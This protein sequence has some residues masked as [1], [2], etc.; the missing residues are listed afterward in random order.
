MTETETGTWIVDNGIVA[1]GGTPERVLHNGAVLWQGERIVEV[2]RAAELGARH[3]EAQHLDAR[4]G[5]I[6]P[7]L[8]NLHH[9]LYS[10]PARGLD[11]GI[12][13][14]GFGPVLE[15]LWWRLD[16]ALDAEAVRLAAALTLTEC[17][18]TGCTTLFDHHASPA[19]LDGSLDLIAAEVERAG[20]SAVLCYEASDRNGRD[21]ALAGLAE[22]LRFH[23]ARRHDPRIRGMLGLHASFTL[24]DATLDRAAA[25][26]PPEAG[27]HIHLAE[28]ILDVRASIDR[29]GAAPVE[30]LHRT[31]L[32]DDRALL[33]HGIHL[34]GSELDTI[35]AAGAVIVHNPESNANNGVG[36]LD[37]ARAL[38]HG[39]TL[40]LGT[41]GMASAMLR[42]LRAAFLGCRAA[43]TDRSAGFAEIP[44]LLPANRAF[45]RRLLDEPL[46]G[47]LTPDA[48]ADLIV[49]DYPPATPLDTTNLFGHLVYAASE[50][51]VRHTIAHGRILMQDHELTT[52]DPVE[53]AEESRAVAPGVWERF[54]RLG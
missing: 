43:T 15:H 32:L 22:S 44:T 34:D 51:P 52:L 12:A 25:D 2:G 16:R 36:R 38:A 7:G 4:G 9:H 31:G 1:T 41:D 20:L 21:E 13:M 8:V 54:R 6:L 46:L 14:N 5:L 45:A 11:P 33:A 18:R 17:I 42:A 35:A 47:E 28:D 27:C 39:C 30:R 40:G 48:P 37:L 26:R 29:H 24:N 19:V 10:L 23:T 49:L 50:A 3:P 53:L